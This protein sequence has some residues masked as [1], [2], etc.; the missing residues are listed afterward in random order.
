[1][2]ERLRDGGN[3]VPVLILSA[4]TLPEDKVRGFDAGA[5]QYINKPFELPELLS[6]V[7]NLLNRHSSGLVMY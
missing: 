2:L 3:H 1:M 4:R 7:N 5:D 6:R